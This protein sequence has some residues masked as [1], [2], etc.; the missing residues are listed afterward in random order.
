VI[1]DHSGYP[2]LYSMPSESRAQA[3]V[4]Q[5]VFLSIM[6]SVMADYMI[7]YRL[8]HRPN[9]MNGSYCVVP[10]RSSE[11]SRPNLMVLCRKQSKKGLEKDGTFIRTLILKHSAMI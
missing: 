10:A 4:P 9:R 1:P 7:L 11:Y 6:G 3:L 5:G 2:L 8:S